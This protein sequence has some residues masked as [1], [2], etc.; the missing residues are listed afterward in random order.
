[1]STCDWKE[2]DDR[3]LCGLT[4]CNL[5]NFA[6]G[7]VIKRFEFIHDQQRA[8]QL[9]YYFSDGNL[10]S[11]LDEEQ[12]KSDDGAQALSILWLRHNHKW[13]DLEGAT[14]N[15]QLLIDDLDDFMENCRK[16]HGVV[17]SIQATFND[18]HHRGGR[19]RRD[20]AEDGWH[21]PQ[22]APATLP[23]PLAASPTSA[24]DAT[25]APATNRPMTQLV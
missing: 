7:P 1:M 13:R 17:N 2:Y 3:E 19:S 20:G 21:L 12:L 14:I 6:F 8:T 11:H 4:F 15:M 10:C 16:E 5:L 25:G 22:M 23:L 9:L 24:T 18:V